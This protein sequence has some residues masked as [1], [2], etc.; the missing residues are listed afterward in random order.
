MD[1]DELDLKFV[2]KTTWEWTFPIRVC[3]LLLSV[4][5]LGCVFHAPDL[6]CFVLYCAAFVFYVWQIVY[7]IRFYRT[8]WA[9]EQ[10][11]AGA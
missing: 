8:H 5:F 11:K 4:V 10:E 2:V 1:R 7:A 3:V 6:F 9:G